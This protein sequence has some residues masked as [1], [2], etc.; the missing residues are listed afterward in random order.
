M[1]KKTSLWISG[2]TTVAMLAVAVGSFAAWNTLTASVQQVQATSSTPTVLTV[3][4]D[5]SSF[6]SK[7][8]VPSDVPPAAGSDEVQSLKTEFTPTLTQDGEGKVIKL[9]T[10][11]LKYNGA[12]N[13]GTLN[14][15]IYKTS[16]TSSSINVSDALT[17]GQSYTIEVEFAKKDTEW[18][19]EMARAAAGKAITLDIECEAADATPASN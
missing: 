5:A 6:T 12:D 13:D 11:D 17:S 15:K 1:K 16:D 3:T 10:A 14:M 19:T 9:K 8:L 7:K 2:I 18:T 4:N